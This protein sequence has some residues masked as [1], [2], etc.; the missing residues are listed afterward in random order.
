MSWPHILFPACLIRFDMC[1]VGDAVA[2]WTY[3]LSRGYKAA[4]VQFSVAGARDVLYVKLSAG[5]WSSGLGTE[6]YS[7]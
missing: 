6:C 4:L 2:A 7:L 1:K 3:A 5:W